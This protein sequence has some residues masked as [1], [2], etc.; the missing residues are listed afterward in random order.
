[1]SALAIGADA[2]LYI[3]GYDRIGYLDIGPD[4]ESRYVDLVARY[5][6]KLSQGAIGNVWD[7]FATDAGVVFRTEHAVLLPSPWTI[8]AARDGEVCSRP[9]RRPVGWFAAAHLAR[10]GGNL[11]GGRPLVVARRTDATGDGGNDGQEL[12]VVRARRQ[13]NRADSDG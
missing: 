10:C 2:R 4:G 11:A 3:G 12:A 1:M 6:G 9:R 8:F 13:R 5:A 7:I